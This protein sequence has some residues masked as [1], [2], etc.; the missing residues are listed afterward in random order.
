MHS[1]W[2]YILYIVLGLNL[3]GNDE[4]VASVF[5]MSSVGE[6]LLN[7]GVYGIEASI[8]ITAVLGV[9]AT[10]LIIGKVRDRFRIPLHIRK[11]ELCFLSR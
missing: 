6:N 8:I 1:I 3:S 7:G 9:A 5:D 2:N 10:L 4:I 11:Q